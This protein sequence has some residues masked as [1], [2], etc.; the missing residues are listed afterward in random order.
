MGLGLAGWLLLACGEADEHG[1]D[2]GLLDAKDPCEVPSFGAARVVTTT[3]AAEFAFPKFEPRGGGLHALW[4]E[5]GVPQDVVGIA[6]WN[7]GEIDFRYRLG[8][9]IRTIPTDFALAAHAPYII[10]SA[11]AG[12]S[13]RTV[14][15]A[16][17]IVVLTPGR[18]GIEPELSS[19]GRHLIFRE[20]TRL[21]EMWLDE[22]KRTPVSEPEEIVL[23]QGVGAM[24]PRFSPSGDR[25]AYFMAGRI[26]TYT[27]ATRERQVVSNAVGQ[28]HVAWLD[29]TTLVLADDR[30][31]SIL[32]EGCPE[33]LFERTPARLVDTH[34]PH[35]SIVFAA[36]GEPGLRYIRGPG[37]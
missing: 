22:R 3:S 20:N 7:D 8:E 4:V 5:D 25:I 15:P 33:T 21:Y 34:R 11:P 19:D 37:R 31:L 29:E 36:V 35:Q 30:G 18:L 26:E 1:L 32:R 27:F 2:A 16:G 28:G 12:L 14:Y 24:R 9:A 17:P 23:T 10:F 13:I 6:Y